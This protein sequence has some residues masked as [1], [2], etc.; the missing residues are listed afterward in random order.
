MRECLERGAEAF[1]WGDR[2]AAGSA[3]EDGE[4]LV[5]WGCAVGAYKAALA[6][7]EAHIIRNGDVLIVTV[8]G[9]EMGQGMRNT[10][11]QMVA[12]Q[13]SV[14]PGLVD[15]R[16]G[17]T[18]D[19][20]QHLSAGSW[21]SP[22][23]AEAVA[24][25]CAK[26]QRDG[27]NEARA[28]VYPPGVPE[29]ARTRFDSGRPIAAGPDFPDFVSLAHAAMF[30]EVHID[31]LT[32]TLRVPRAL[33]VID[34]GRVLSGRMARSQ[35][36]GGLVWGIA[37]ALHDGTEIDGRYGGWLNRDLGEYLVPVSADIRDLDTILLDEPDPLLGAVG[38]KGLGEV[39]MTG[40]SAAIANAV[41][42]VTG[43]R[44]RSLPILMDVLH[45]EMR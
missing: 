16:M 11:A 18:G 17:V 21:G 26:L 13:L 4:T 33:S 34:C 45:A 7:G 24:A 25:A 39:S 32:R 29:E 44:V 35:G 1:G 6:I 15:V 38:A 14:K 8:S 20:P 10:V 36:L 22:T 31:R 27:G 2:P 37:S 41:R 19:V 42:H 3:T 28:T 5:G 9:H 40:T 43:V 23:A 12:D 30:V